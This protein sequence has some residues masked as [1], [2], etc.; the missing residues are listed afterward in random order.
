MSTQRVQKIESL[1][2][3]VVAT[4]IPGLIGRDSARVTVTGVDAAPDLRNATV[5]L[6]VLGTNRDPDGEKLYAAVV[7]EKSSLQ[8]SLARTLT[9]KFVPHLTL[10]QDT[11]G[12]YAEHITRIMQ[13]M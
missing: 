6:G 9:T 13:Q 10:K 4:Q 8:S 12:A 7:A 1:I 5:W 2:Q 3:Q 11:G